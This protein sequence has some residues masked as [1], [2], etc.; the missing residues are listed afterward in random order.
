MRLSALVVVAALGVGPSLAAECPDQT[1]RGLDE[2]AGASFKRA[3][4]ALNRAY[5]EI[6]HRLK[7]DAA[8]TKLLVQAQKA[9]LNW[10]D[11]ECAFSSSG[12]QGGSIYP[13]IVA[14]CQE[15]QT[16]ARM[17]DLRGYLTCAEGD[18]DCPVLGR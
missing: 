2:C 9:W 3:D 13:M 12:V 16:R 1:Q 14:Q 18:L 4:A 11:A 6:V 15:K 17:K 5:K 8:K 7:D 10:R